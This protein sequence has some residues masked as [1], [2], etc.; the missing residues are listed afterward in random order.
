M[1]NLL[2]LASGLHILNALKITNNVVYSKQVMRW[3]HQTT[4]G[5][6]CGSG[7]LR[8]WVHGGTCVLLSDGE[9]ELEFGWELFLRVQSIWKIDSTDSAVSMD[10]NTKSFNIVCTIG[11]SSEIREVE[12]YLIPTFIQAHRHSADKRFHSSRRL[13]YWAIVFQIET[14]YLIVWST[15][16]TADIFVIENHHLKSEV[17]SQLG[18]G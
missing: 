9:E 4:L 1:I 8:A 5:G 3:F 15:K 17:L 7:I 10:L 11:S 12:L 13:K 16:A 2:R 6:Y 18:N 14:E